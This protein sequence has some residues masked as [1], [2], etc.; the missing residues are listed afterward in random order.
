M[1]AS[2][3]IFAI[4]LF[5]AFPAITQSRPSKQEPSSPY[6]LELHAAEVALN[7]TVLDSKGQL[8]KGL[9]KSNFKVFEIKFP[10][11]PSPCSIKTGL[12]RPARR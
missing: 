11:P 8:V 7:C 10:R 6:T 9:N 1:K 4:L 2:S 3:A 12:H 5:G